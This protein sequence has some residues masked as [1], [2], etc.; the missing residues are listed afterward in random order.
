V[1]ELSETAAERIVKLMRD[2]LT[3]AST[4][5]AR[6]RLLPV[7]QAAEVELAARLKRATG[8]GLLYTAAVAAA[9]R[10]QVRA[11]IKELSKRLADVVTDLSVKAS[12]ES[13]HALVTQLRLAEAALGNTPRPA[14]S[15]A[16][17]ARL[18]GA[19]GRDTSL[20]QHFLDRGN[21]SAVSYGQQLITGFEDVIAKGLASGASTDAVSDNL[22]TKS[23]Q[24]LAGAW[25][26]AERIARTEISYA[27]N[28]TAKEGTKEVATLFPDALSRWVEHVSDETRQP[29]DDRVG[30]D[31]LRLHGQLRLPGQ[32][33][34]DI[35]NKRDVYEPPNRPN[36][37][38]TLTVWRASWGEPPGGLARLDGQSKTAFAAALAAMP[39]P[40]PAQAAPRS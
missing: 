21:A 12:G 24:G 8:S 37:R 36:D 18:T 15:I 22:L 7:L 28:V 35:V 17:V 4:E 9:Y 29:L 14:L 30:D 13:A 6:S 38:A 20:L 19:L 1:A 25:W 11:V 39:K 40:K 23:P 16:Q 10:V 2:R 34:H 31:S 27:Y 3:A 26:R 33:F 5:A 32:A